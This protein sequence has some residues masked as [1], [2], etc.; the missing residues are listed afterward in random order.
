MVDILKQY[1]YIENISTNYLRIMN[2][3]QILKLAETLGE[4]KALKRQ[5]WVRRKVKN[6]ESD[7]D[8]SYSLA[9]LVMLF[10]PKN[11]NLLKCMQLAL[12]HDLPEIYCGDIV[13]G[14]L[15]LQKK[16]NLEAKAMQKVV[17]DLECPQLQELFMEYELRTTPEARFVWALDRLDNVFTAKKYEDAGHTGLVE[18][19]AA[20]ARERIECLEDDSLRE[21]LSQILD[22]LTA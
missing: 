19:F 15:D 13:P 12:V 17:Q 7:A 10:A 5:G 8:H 11:L 6:P 22:T 9:L 14:E 18:E 21:Y 2:K 3:K 20:S 1:V 4:M 16:F